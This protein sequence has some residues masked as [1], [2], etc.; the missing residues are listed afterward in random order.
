M[1]KVFFLGIC[2]LLQY[3]EKV[4]TVKPEICSAVAQLR[5][6]GSSQDPDL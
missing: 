6:G 2:I 5:I 4:Q 1:G 3:P